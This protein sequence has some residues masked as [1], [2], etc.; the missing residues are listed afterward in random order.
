M[1]GKDTIKVKGYRYNINLQKLKE[2]IKT[3]KSCVRGVVH[4]QAI[5]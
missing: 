1:N 4:K 5:R 2:L 3:T